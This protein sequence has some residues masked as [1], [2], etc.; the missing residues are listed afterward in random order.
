M[1][2]ALCSGLTRIG[3]ETELESI[4]R[5]E[6]AGAGT[7]VAL[8]T[9][10]CG[11]IGKAIARGIAG[12]A[13][14]EVVLVCRDEEKARHACQEITRDTGNR[15]VRYETVDVSRRSSIQGLAARWE[16]PLHV[17]VNNAAV[18]PRRREETPEGIERQ[19]ATNSSTASARFEMPSRRTGAP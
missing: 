13:G 5:V 4:R 16:G 1:P 15:E 18:T 9:G 3:T 12:T 11:A 8:V 10:A 2:F 14:Y 7:R 19:F 6:Q 17:L